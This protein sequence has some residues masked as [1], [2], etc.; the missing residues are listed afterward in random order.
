[1]VRLND[2]F[3]KR[4]DQLVNWEGLYLGCAASSAAQFFIFELGYEILPKA[5]SCEAASNM[6][7]QQNQRWHTFC[8]IVEAHRIDHSFPYYDYFIEMV[9]LDTNIRD[10]ME[11][12]RE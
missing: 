8:S 7:H 1:M 3:E 11:A 5:T 6:I 2:I 12:W 10:Q 4:K 9:A